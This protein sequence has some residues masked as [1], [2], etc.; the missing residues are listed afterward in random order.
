MPRIAILGANGQVGAELCLLLSRM[1]DCELVPICRNPTGS[2]FLR[3]SGIACRHGL[4]A[5]PGEA[6]QL[7]G[8]CDVIVN[9]ALGTGTPAEIR[10]FDRRLVQNI[11]SHSRPD[12][13]I[14][15][16]STL[17]VHGDPRRG[18]RR[19]VRDAYGRAKFAAERLILA[20]SKRSGKPGYILRLGH[21][22]GPLQ[23]ITDRIQK[24]IAIGQVVLPEDDVASNT[25]YTVT[26]VDAIMSVLA[27]K[28][29][30]GEY[31]LT[32]APQWT[33][34]QV[35]SYEGERSHQAFAPQL[36]PR[37][38]SQGLLKQLSLPAGR[39][40][41]RW[42][43]TPVIRRTLEK[44]LAIAPAALNERAQASWFK[45]RAGVEIGAIV[46]APV[47]APELSWIRL[48]R[49]PMTSLQSTAKLLSADPYKDLTANIQ[50][51]WPKDLGLAAASGITAVKPVH[52]YPH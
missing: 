10:S 28:E 25:V 45:M 29:R 22:C 13:T 26:I 11:F 5:E 2:A 41:R 8:D 35:Y 40:M 34:R 33:W 44:W 37:P 14:I 27:G 20:E 9:C 7:I 38:I 15:H 39:T 4:P 42:A 49:H 32:N 52:G 23:N 16:F 50:N 47:L 3:Y 30:P 43:R 31:D 36:V 12:A 1:P 6:P 24:E 48:D 21:V 18:K 51:R 17:M 46:A 19:R